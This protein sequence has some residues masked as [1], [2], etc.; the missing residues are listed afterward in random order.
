MIRKYRLVQFLDRVP[1]SSWE[2][3]H[4]G[5]Y[6]RVKLESVPCQQPYPE[7]LYGYGGRQEK[8]Q[9]TAR[10]S[11]PV[12]RRCTGCP[13]CATPLQHEC[14]E[15][16]LQFPFQVVH[17]KIRSQRLPLEAGI[18][19]LQG[20]IEICRNE[21]DTSDRR[22]PGA[23]VLLHRRYPLSLKMGPNVVVAECRRMRHDCKT[24]FW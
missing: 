1:E 9:K 11:S 4:A 16:R 15:S 8:L 7:P 13:C 23:L 21:V 19:L 6:S 17:K 3:A 22:V 18:P 24:R 14:A 5:R 10:H 12:T 2:A 20:G